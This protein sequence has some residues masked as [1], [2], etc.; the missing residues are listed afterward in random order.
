MHTEEEV[1]GAVAG[2]EPPALLFQI[3]G[4]RKQPYVWHPKPPLT[5]ILKLNLNPNSM[6]TFQLK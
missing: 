6:M 1:K 3:F 5:S 4:R 2:L